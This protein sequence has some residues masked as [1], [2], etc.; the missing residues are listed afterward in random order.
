MERDSTSSVMRTAP[1]SRMKNLR[2]TWWT[3]ARPALWPS[4]MK[5]YLHMVRVTSTASCSDQTLGLTTEEPQNLFQQSRH[6][7][8]LTMS[9]IGETSSL[10]PD[11]NIR[12]HLMDVLFSIQRW[13]T[14]GTTCLGARQTVTS[15]TCTILSFGPLS[16]REEWPT[17]LHRFFWFFY[18]F[19]Q[20]QNLP[21]FARS[22]WREPC[23]ERR[24]RFSFLNLGSTT[25]RSRNSS[26]RGQQFWGKRWKSHLTMEQRGRSWGRKFSPWIVISLEMSSGRKTRTSLQTLADTAEISLSRS[27]SWILSQ[28]CPWSQILPSMRLTGCAVVPVVL[29]AFHSSWQF[30]QSLGLCGAKWQN[31]CCRE[32]L[33]W[34]GCSRDILLWSSR[35]P[36]LIL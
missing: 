4:S 29:I 7:L 11:W 25:T 30:L 32:W 17:K 12:L 20:E 33:V 1:P 14:W 8:R 2:W 34:K 36:T 13:G 18:I 6:C 26:R 21:N 28:S 24:T 31:P 27:W 9:S 19:D 23:L 22:G 5:S 35:C 3:S 10:T 16:N 15:T